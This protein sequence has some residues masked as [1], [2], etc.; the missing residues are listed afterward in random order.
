M[1]NLRKILAS[2]GLI[3]SGR[4]EW[5]VAYTLKGS[6]AIHGDSNYRT[7]QA[8]LESARLLTQVYPNSTAVFYYERDYKTLEPLGKVETVRGK[9]PKL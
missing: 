7:E 9:A 1:K 2:E 5:H 8:A 3:A 6:H 4:K